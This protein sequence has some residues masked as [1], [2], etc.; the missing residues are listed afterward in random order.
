MQSAS[1]VAK[2]TKTF[3]DSLY[4]LIVTDSSLTQKYITAILREIINLGNVQLVDSQDAAVKHI[5]NNSAQKC[6]FIFYEDSTAPDAHHD[7]IAAIRQ[8]QATATT[9]IVVLGPQLP[10]NHD[11]EQARLKLSNFL[12][13]PFVPSTLISL[14]FELFQEKD[15][16]LAKRINTDN[17]PCTV[18]MGYYATK[19]YQAHML[20]ISYTGCL[21]QTQYEFDDCGN[22]D[23]IGSVNFST[24]D[25][26][27]IHLSGKIVRADEGEH[28]QIGFQFQ[29]N[30]EEDLI[31]LG[32]FISVLS[33]LKIK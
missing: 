19:P 26:T 5:Q 14:L 12:Q 9:P 29:N 31:K 11:S 1:S 4:A 23:D 13:R 21:V 20:N 33:K 6:S 25:G 2:Q 16:R 22:L 28:H 17:L 24:T 7:F 15:R 3:D 18:D 32:R 10:D 30:E 27:K 8:E